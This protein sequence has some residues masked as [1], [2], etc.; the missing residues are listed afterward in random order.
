MVTGTQEAV[1]EHG[2]R[3]AVVS[4][5]KRRVGAYGKKRWIRTAATYDTHLEIYDDDNK[6]KLT[7]MHNFSPS[8][9]VHAATAIHV[10]NYAPFCVPQDLV[11]PDMWTTHGVVWGLTRVFCRA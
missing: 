7:R 6:N 10:Q 4:H 8:L 5:S 9:T 1:V 2:K 11:K 3:C